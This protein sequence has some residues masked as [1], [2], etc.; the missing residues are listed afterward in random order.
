MIVGATSTTTVCVCVCVCVGESPLRNLS[1][2]HVYLDHCSSFL[3]SCH[4]RHRSS[5]QYDQHNTHSHKGSPGAIQKLHTRYELHAN[6]FK[7]TNSA[8]HCSCLTLH[9]DVDISVHPDS[10]RLS[11][12]INL[13]NSLAI[14]GT[15]VRREGTCDGQVTPSLIESIV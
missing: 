9:H 11:K 4:C 6:I 12:T 2:C 10:H 3:G 14:V 1:S 8:F 5:R 7:L 13:E 15:T